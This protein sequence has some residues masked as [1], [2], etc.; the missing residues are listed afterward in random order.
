MYIDKKEKIMKRTQEEPMK[1]QKNLPGKRLKTLMES[2]NSNNDSSTNVHN[3]DQR[4]EYGKLPPP[5]I[6]TIV[7]MIPEDI[8]ALSNFSQTC[9]MNVVLSLRRINNYKENFKQQKLKESFKFRNEMDEL[10]CTEPGSALVRCMVA[11]LNEKIRTQHENRD[12]EQASRDVAN[13]K[14]MINSTE[15]VFDIN[16]Y[17][18]PESDRNDETD[19]RYMFGWFYTPL[20]FAIC[21]E[22]EDLVDMLLEHPMF[23]YT[24]FDPPLMWPVLLHFSSEQYALTCLQKLE[25]KFKINV[26]SK[27]TSFLATRELNLFQLALIHRRFNILK[28]VMEQPSFCVESY[29][30]G[31]LEGGFSFLINKIY[32]TSTPT[33]DEE[34]GLIIRKEDVNPDLRAE[35]MD[36]DEFEHS[37]HVNPEIKTV[38]DWAICMSKMGKCDDDIVECIDMACS[39][40]MK[41]P[42]CAR[43]GMLL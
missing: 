28:W 33:E 22:E 19:W 8:D 39:V 43:K 18:H 42:H 34:S 1:N 4:F 38:R 20:H 14:K 23:D 2:S 25:K 7:N 3:N 32:D 5:I 24:N 37:F 36:T 21:A 9:R 12:E 30:A 6:C 13:A 26:N 35:D 11:V 27:A 31:D 41:Y 40:G 29:L 10:Y 17:Y 15:G 16:D